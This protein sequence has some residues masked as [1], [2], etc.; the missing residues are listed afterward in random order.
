MWMRVGA[1]VGGGAARLGRGDRGEAGRSH[2]SLTRR[3]GR[4]RL[5]LAAR[6]RS[7]IT[8]TLV[9]SS[10]NPQQPAAARE[11][12]RQD[13]ALVTSSSNPQQPAAA[14]ER[15][16]QD[17]ALVRAVAAG[18]EGAIG[19]L[20]DRY[21]GVLLAVARR[22]LG[23]SQEAEDLV[24]DVFVEAW[25]HALRYDPA[26]ASVRTW[27]LVRCRSRALDRIRSPRRS[28]RTDLRD[29]P[30]RRSGPEA[31]PARHVERVRVRARVVALAPRYR[32][33]IEKAYFG[34]LSAREIAE[35]EGLPL[36]TVKSRI[37]AAMRA[38]RS[39]MAAPATSVKAAP[40]ASAQATHLQ[41]RLSTS[42]SEA[43][44]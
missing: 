21:A 37:A 3:F 12:A 26:R 15:A 31:D 34:G 22:M 14:R 38:L 35:Q 41:P 44:S 30:E 7:R 11:R 32:V 5:R 4:N 43:Q 33:L 27:L 17:V 23:S 1:V 42:D 2:R 25:R 10:S 9:T 8:I 39:A 40:G 29:M 18:E 24:H 20:Y 28:R 13:V 16:R 36:G 6:Y 19:E